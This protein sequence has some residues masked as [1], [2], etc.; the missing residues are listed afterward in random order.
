[1]FRLRFWGTI[2]FSV[3]LRSSKIK[4]KPI[5][6]RNACKRDGSLAVRYREL[7]LGVRVLFWGLSFGNNKAQ[8]PIVCGIQLSL[9]AAVSQEAFVISWATQ[10]ALI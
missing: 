6:Q 8:S 7:C 3:Q 2:K 9:P 5:K 10:V 1:M 4:R